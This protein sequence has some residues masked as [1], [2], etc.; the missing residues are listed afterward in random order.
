MSRAA[1]SPVRPDGTDRE[2][3]QVV[4]VIAVALLLAGIL[5][6][7]LVRLGAV[8]A[9]QA[10]AQAAADAVALAGAAGGEEAARRV[11]GENHARIVEMTVTPG[12]AAV[13]VE[14]GGH[15]ASARARRLTS[16]SPVPE[17]WRRPSE[18]GA[19]HPVDCRPCLIAPVKP[20][21]M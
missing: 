18:A 7:G 8:A 4:P 3:G 14:R 17:F 19:A 11:A 21:P 2:R 13:T 1:R 10:A 16:E 9:R 20:V 15:S 5:G 6:L 12:E